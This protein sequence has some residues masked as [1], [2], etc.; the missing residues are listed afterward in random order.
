MR[1]D[2][3]TVRVKLSR[4]HGAGELA[5]AAVDADGFKEAKSFVQTY[6]YPLIR[7]FV[8]G[9]RPKIATE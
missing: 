2:S 3:D 7:A 1:V 4:I 5:A 8:S 6:E 9:Q